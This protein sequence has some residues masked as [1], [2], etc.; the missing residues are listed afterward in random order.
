MA[1]NQRRK[2]LNSASAVGYSSR[3]PYRVK[4]KNFS[5]PQTDANLR[6]H[7]SLV[8]DGSKKRVVSK[9]EQVGISWRKLRPFVDSVSNEHAIIADVLDVPREIFDLEN[10]SEV[11]SLEVAIFL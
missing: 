6:S 9:R 1:A 2:R 3:E 8:W 10:L 7:I 5:L 4:K 11:L